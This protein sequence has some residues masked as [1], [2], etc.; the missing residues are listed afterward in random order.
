MI[1]SLSSKDL[2]ASG[3]DSKAT[4]EQVNAVN[5][6]TYHKAKGLEW[7]I[8]ICTDLETQ[9]RPRLWEVTLGPVD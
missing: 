5:V 6:S 2:V 1:V 7:P 8:V 3:A 4:D 9:P